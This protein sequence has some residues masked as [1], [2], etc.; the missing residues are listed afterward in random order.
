[1]FDTYTKQKSIEDLY[2]YNQEG[3]RGLLD[4]YYK[5]VEQGTYSYDPMVIVIKMDIERALRST[6][7]QPNHLSILTM[8]YALQLSFMEIQLYEGTSI[9]EAMNLE[10]EAIQIMVDVLGGTPSDFY[11]YEDIKPAETLSEHLLDVQQVKVSPYN[12]SEALMTHLL[13]LT[14]QRD[15]H[16]KEVLRQR[17]E[18]APKLLEVLPLDIEY[19]SHN[20]SVHNKSNYDYFRNQDRKNQVSYDGFVNQARGLQVVG[21]KKV[22]TSSDLAGNKGMVYEL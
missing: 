2:E 16:A 3:V 5:L 11:Q 20:T 9:E 12:V 15:N 18:G 10:D 21:R 19:P 13:H 17:V 1:M 8:R 7:L 4:N 14:K 22:R 6:L